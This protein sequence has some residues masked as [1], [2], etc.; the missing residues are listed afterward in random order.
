[1]KYANVWSKILNHNE[2]VKYEFSIGD[3]YRK[4]RLIFNLVISSFFLLLALIGQ[5]YFLFKVT[6]VAVI[7]S[8]V[9]FWYQKVS[10]AYAFT[11]RRVLI[12]HGWLSTKAQS[13]D[14]TKIT[15]VSVSEPF[16]SRV[17][18]GSGDMSIHTGNI[19][20]ALILKSVSQPYEIKKKLDSFRHG[21]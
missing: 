17:I 6:I 5:S 12:H 19:T 13:V 18:T 7:L 9:W 4:F 16:L 3:K 14:Y 2:E 8:I 10:N 1:M 11:D 15:E 20:D 21:L